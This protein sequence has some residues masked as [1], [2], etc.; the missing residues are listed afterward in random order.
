[1][2]I[3]TKYKAIDGTEFFDKEKCE[4]YAPAFLYLFSFFLKKSCLKT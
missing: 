1:M 2:K 3:I 4:K